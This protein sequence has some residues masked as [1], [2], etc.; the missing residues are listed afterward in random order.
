MRCSTNSQA[1]D[2]FIEC[3]INYGV[4]EGGEGFNYGLCG[5]GASWSPAQEHVNPIPR[6][7]KHMRM[8]L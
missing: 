7:E 5:L 8:A 1:Q 4:F 2:V 3:K 6:I